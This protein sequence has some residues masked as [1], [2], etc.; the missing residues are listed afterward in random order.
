[1]KLRKLLKPSYILCMIL[2]YITAVFGG[3]FTVI[4]HVFHLWFPDH[5]ITLFLGPFEP[6]FSYVNLYFY[7][8]PELYS[9]TSFLTLSFLSS[10]SLMG[11]ALLFLWYISRL[12]KNIDKKGLFKKVNVSILY[13]LG[14]ATLILVTIYSNIDSY[15]LKQAIQELEIVNADLVLE[16]FPYFD[17]LFSAVGFFIFAFA[18]NKAIR[19]IEGK[20]Q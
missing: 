15:L 20:E 12:I 9:S 3:I 14:I 7:E 11:W 16:D 10:I 13:K 8:H 19:A 17:G 2:F 1:M 18:L 4:D 6:V 5:P